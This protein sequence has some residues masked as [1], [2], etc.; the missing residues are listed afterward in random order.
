MAINFLA[1]YKLSNTQKD[2]NKVSFLHP[3]SIR[4]WGNFTGV[5]MA[6]QLSQDVFQLSSKPSVEFVKADNSLFSWA[7]PK[8]KLSMEKFD[9]KSMVLIHS[10]NYYPEQGKI[11]SARAG[12]VDSNGVALS[13]PTIHFAL[14]KPVTE[15][16]VGNNWNTMDYVTILPFDSTVSSMPQEHVIGGIKDDFAFMHEVQMPKGSV[17]VKYNPEVPDGQFKVSEAFDGIKLVESSNR[18]INESA[19]TV[20]KKMGYQHYSDSMR[21]YLGLNDEEMQ[22]LGARTEFEALEYLKARSGNTQANLDTMETQLKALDDLKGIL[23]EQEIED[24]RKM[25]LDSIETEKVVSKCADKLSESPKYWEE[26]CTKNGYDTTLHSVS[27]WGKAEMALVGLNIVKL[28]NNNSWEG[29]DYKA[30]LLKTLDAAVELLPEGKELGYDVPKIKTIIAESAT[31]QE[32]QT[33][34]EQELKIKMM[35]L[36]NESADENSFELGA[37]FALMWLGI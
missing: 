5:K 12:C 26:F 32:A 10:T 36:R 33:R 20:I 24:S 25:I 16:S 29:D 23:S 28:L 7:S 9:P 13:R 34:M 37:D 35:S 27:A 4:A 2:N 17:I 31:P 21:E 8:P 11:Q 18:N 14:N 15:H 19:S 6:P 22:K 30:R 1:G 3:N